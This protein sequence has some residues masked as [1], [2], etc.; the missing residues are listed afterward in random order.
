MDYFA[1]RVV[2]R[3]K[4]PYT[5]SMESLRDRWLYVFVHLKGLLRGFS[6]RTYA[7]FGEDIV[8][9][10][11]LTGSKGFFVDV[12]AFHPFHYSNTYF[13][14]KKG[15]R[16]INIDPNPSSIALFRIH[17]PGDRSVNAGI[18]RTPGTAIYYQFN[19]QACNTFSQEQ[20][21]RMRA[22]KFVREIGSRV[23][24]LAPLSTIIDAE[25]PHE[26]PD[27]INIDVEGMNAEVLE[28]LDWS[29]HAPR[30]LCVEDDDLTFGKAIVS[31]IH[32]LL[33]GKGYRLVARMGPSSV[34]I[35]EGVVV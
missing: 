24:P 3:G 31:P 26:R 1:R 12:G 33:V 14:Y 18:G 20:R 11:Y 13:L 21:E 30:V 15:W 5:Q 17:R 34:Y 32:Q 7:Q 28:T 35:Q 23:I 29:R 19:H 16:G 4:T 27:F 10:P 9:A 2:R 6:R 22:K 25:R 8:L